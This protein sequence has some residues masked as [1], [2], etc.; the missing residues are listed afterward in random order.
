MS[1]GSRGGCHG[2]IVVMCRR[3]LDE[4]G[5]GDDGKER[6]EEDEI[7]LTQREEE[8]REEECFKGK[9]GRDHT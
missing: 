9:R 1:S 6:N 4:E 3:R 8:E 5:E 7:N 2:D